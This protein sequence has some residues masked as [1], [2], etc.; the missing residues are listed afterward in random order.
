MCEK[1]RSTKIYV[2]VV[3]FLL[4]MPVNFSE[5]IHIFPLQGSHWYYFPS[6]KMVCL[7][8]VCDTLE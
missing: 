4:E 1:E 7:I 3:D 8:S 5:Y 6:S 2:V